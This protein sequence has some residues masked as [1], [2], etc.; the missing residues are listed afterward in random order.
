MKSADFSDFAACFDNINKDVSVK[1]FMENWLNEPG[2]PAVIVTKVIV[3][4]IVTKVVTK[5]SVK[6]QYRKKKKAGQKK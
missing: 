3:T 4:K 2:L 1:D 6:L 5:A